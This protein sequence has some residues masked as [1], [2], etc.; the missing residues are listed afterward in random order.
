MG[1]V[2]ISYPVGHPG[3]KSRTFP[4]LQWEPD[5]QLFQIFSAAGK[6]PCFNSFT[7]CLP[8]HHP[9]LPSPWQLQS[10]VAQ[11][12]N[13][14]NVICGF[15][16]FLYNLETQIL[17]RVFPLPCAH[18]LPPYLSSCSPV[19]FSIQSLG[20]H[21]LLSSEG[22]WLLLAP[23][24]EVDPISPQLFSF[25]KEDTH[26]CNFWILFELTKERCS[27]FVCD[28]ILKKIPLHFSL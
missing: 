22:Y 2:V 15:N 8:S 21:W 26:C 20:F 1:L 12:S 19:G 28:L 16:W 7:A 4:G 25:F 10:F 9:H 13:Q 27:Y 3:T 6:N 23:F 17:F 14:Q 5:S 11:E 24:H 18:L